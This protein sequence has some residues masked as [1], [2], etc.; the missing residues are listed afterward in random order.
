[1]APAATSTP[2]PHVRSKLFVP[3]RALGLVSNHIPLAVRY[4]KRRREHLIVTCVG[5]AFHT[6]G[7]THLSLLST[8]PQH[9]GDICCLAVDTYHVYTAVGSQV[10]SLDESAAGPPF[11]KNYEGHFT[12]ISME[13]SYNWH[14]FV[15]WNGGPTLDLQSTLSWYQLHLYLEMEL[16]DF[17]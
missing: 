17:I 15:L 9:A 7:F 14:S 12:V 6:Y 4:I 16:W 1:M 13:E 5:R 8:S 2:A 3:A 10:R 11:C